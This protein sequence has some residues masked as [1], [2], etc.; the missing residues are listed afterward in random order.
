MRIELTHPAPEAGALSTEL[1]GHA[2]IVY[3]SLD[4]PATAR[5]LLCAQMLSV[6]RPTLPPDV[7]SGGHWAAD[8]TSAASGLTCFA[9]TRNYTFLCDVLV[10]NR[11]IT[12]L[13]PVVVRR[14][15]CYST[16]EITNRGEMAR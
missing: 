2:K 9:G 5:Q 12:P 15:A 8:D 13:K 6:Y 11:S 10:R 4:R 3:H 14:P 1:R 16:R 7:S